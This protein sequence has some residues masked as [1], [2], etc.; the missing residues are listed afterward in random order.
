M[1][2]LCP[3]RWTVRHGAIEAV[4]KNYE[5]LQDTFRS[6][7]ETCHDD[8]GRRAGGL[9]AVMEKF[10]TYFGLQL[11]DLVFAATEQLS[12]SLQSKNTTIM[13]AL[14]ATKL[15][16]NHL[17]RLRDETTFDRFYEKTKSAASELTAEPTLPRYRHKP[18]RLADGSLPH[19]YDSVESCHRHMFY[20]VLE[21]LVGVIDKRFNQESLKVPRA[22]EASLIKACRSDQEGET[23]DGPLVPP[24]VE[25]LY[26]KDLDLKRLK[27]QMK[28][29][30]DLVRSCPD[31]AAEVT[32]VRTLAS[33]L[34][35]EP[36]ASSM[37]SEVDKLVRIYLTLPVTTAT[38]ER[39]FS[40]LRRIKT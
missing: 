16:R 8:Y 6:V 13:E 40:A 31:T 39:S 5:A 1:R 27:R 37:F 17:T 18:R 38:G 22:I 21:V 14:H 15:A 29:L 26:A 3:T 2:P 30:P 20:E 35:T 23:D 12:V 4:L 36:L 9:L 24:A 32:K 7:N 11:V 19:R 10:D 33:M 34:A 25:K 28:M